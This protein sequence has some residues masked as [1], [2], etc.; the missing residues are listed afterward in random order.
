M[1]QKDVMSPAG[2]PEGKS[3]VTARRLGWDSGDTALLQQD[4]ES[5]SDLELGFGACFE[6][7]AERGC[8]QISGMGRE[9][10]TDPEGFRDG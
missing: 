2:D 6:G 5:R 4:E 10:C 3:R 9:R 7:R 8:G 1:E